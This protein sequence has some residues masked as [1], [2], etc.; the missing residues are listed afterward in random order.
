MTTRI[1]QD[2]AN[3]RQTTMT[4]LQALLLIVAVLAG[5]LAIVFA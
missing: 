2:Y 3:R 4:Q 1:R 5:T